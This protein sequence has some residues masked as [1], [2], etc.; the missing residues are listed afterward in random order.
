MHLLVNTIFRS[1]QILTYLTRTYYVLEKI[2]RSQIHTYLI[3][4]LIRAYIYTETQNLPALFADAP[5]RY[6]LSRQPC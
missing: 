2:S 3:T 5:G 1:S 6:L 4:T